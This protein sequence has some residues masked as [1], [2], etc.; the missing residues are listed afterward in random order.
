[1]LS[2]V[3]SL[4]G[5][6]VVGDILPSHGSTRTEVQSL[7]YLRAAHSL[8]GGVWIEDKVVTLNGQPLAVDG[9]GKP[10][11]DSIYSAFVLQEAVR[12]FQS[13]GQQ[14]GRKENALVM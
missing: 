8:I 9:Q 11:G 2:S 1:V 12:L 7:R 4:T 3:P 10:L 6:I 13:Q 14:L 5:V